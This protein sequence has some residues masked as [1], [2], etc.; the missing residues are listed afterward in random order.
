[1]AELGILSFRMCC[2]AT[3]LN[4]CVRGPLA[5]AGNVGRRIG[6]EPLPP[7]DLRFHPLVSVRPELSAYRARPTATL[8][9][10][11]R[12]PLLFRCCWPLIDEHLLNPEVHRGF[13]R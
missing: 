3:C 8:L 5:P 4:A 12:A 9:T 10:P 7:I 2:V 11:D 13:V 6:C 1:L